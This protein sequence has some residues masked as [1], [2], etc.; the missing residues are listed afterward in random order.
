LIGYGQFVVAHDTWDVKIF[1][2]RD[3]RVRFRTI[4][5]IV[6]QTDHVIDIRSADIEQDLFER[7][8]V[9]MNIRYNRNSHGLGTMPTSSTT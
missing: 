3:N 9:R 6:T 7:F 1:D 4:T 5:D 2:H 8:Q